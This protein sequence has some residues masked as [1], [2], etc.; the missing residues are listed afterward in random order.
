MSPAY[1][2][3]D[4]FFFLGFLD[5]DFKVE[6]LSPSAASSINFLGRTTAHIREI[7][8]HAVVNPV[9]QSPKMLSPLPR[10]QSPPL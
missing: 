9:V 8:N 2:F 3:E 4:F 6:S 5:D 7:K 1:F 10:I